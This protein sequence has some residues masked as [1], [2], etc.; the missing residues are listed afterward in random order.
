MDGFEKLGSFAFFAVSALSPLAWLLR[1]SPQHIGN[2]AF[3]L[4]RICRGEGPALHSRVPCEQEKQASEAFGALPAEDERIPFGQSSIA[5]E[6]QGLIAVIVS[7]TER[8]A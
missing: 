8:Y 2:I 6:T 7:L 4:S 1:L 3:A 5:F